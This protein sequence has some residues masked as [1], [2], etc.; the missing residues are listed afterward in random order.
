M[1][2]MKLEK[3]LPVPTPVSQPYWSALNEQRV[4]IQ[5]CGD[6]QAWVFYPRNRCSSCL[7]ENLSWH[8]VS[9]MGTL[10][11]F[12]LTRQ[13]TSP[14]FVDDMPQKLAIVELAEGVRLTTTLVN[15]EEDAIKV[16]MAVKPVFDQVSDEITMLRYEPA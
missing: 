11:T 1:S 6:C 7:S 16:G 10:Y 4:V 14:H 15:V 8:E 3:P 9:G 5:R 13:P 12:T 2:E